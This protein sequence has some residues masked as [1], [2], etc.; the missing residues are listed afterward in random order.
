MSIL[1]YG[2]TTWELT[3]H[4]E[5]KL[6][7]NYTRILR[8]IV[9]KYW[10]QHPT[11]QQLYGYLPPIT[12]TIQVRRTRHAGHCWGSRD[13]LISDI[14]LWTPSHWRAN[15]GR[16]ARILIQQICADTKCSPEDLPEVMDE[17]EECRERVRDMSAD[18][19]NLWY[20]WKEVKLWFSIEF[21]R[22]SETFKSTD[23]AAFFYA[24]IN[25]IRNYIYLL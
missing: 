14:I 18:G 15:A 4:L 25:F 2:C 1:L 22:P 19:L 24:N 16:P 23:C 5:K 8:A 7:D 3:K 13:E 21:F 11:K 9:T 12:K 20:W 17:R 6:D 10:R